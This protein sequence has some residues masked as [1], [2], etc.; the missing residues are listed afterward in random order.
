MLSWRHFG[1]FHSLICIP[2]GSQMKAHSPSLLL[3]RILIFVCLFSHINWSLT[4][5]FWYMTGIQPPSYWVAAVLSQG[6]RKARL[7]LWNLSVIRATL[8]KLGRLSD[9]A[10]G[11]GFLPEV[12]LE[13]CIAC[14]RRLVRS[15][16]SSRPGSVQR[17]PVCP[18]T[19]SSSQYMNP[20][21]VWPWKSS[22][23]LLLH[24]FSFSLLEL[25]TWVLYLHHLAPPS[26]SFFHAHLSQ[27]HDY[28]N[29]CC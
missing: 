28:F 29:Y 26:P 20:F 9:L 15:L 21:S 1:P 16:N 5:S 19:H 14:H 22:L 7:W 2:L 4:D 13:R 18:Q 10:Y 6:C 3:L 27:F 11:K 23:M 8:A 24:C 25:L 17:P 12:W